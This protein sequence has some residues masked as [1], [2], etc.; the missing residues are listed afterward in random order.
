MHL[1]SALDH[2]DCPTVAV[3]EGDDYPLGEHPD[4]T[5]VDLWS[6]EFRTRACVAMELTWGM[7]THYIGM[8]QFPNIPID[9]AELLH[10]P[11]SWAI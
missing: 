7:L 3:V 1:N 11:R 5:M 10:V 2:R 6:I 9:F 8:D 4:I